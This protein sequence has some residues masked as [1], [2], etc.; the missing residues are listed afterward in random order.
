[1]DRD[2]TGKCVYVHRVLIFTIVYDHSVTWRNSFDLLKFWYLIWYFFWYF[3]LRLNLYEGFMERN[4]FLF[5]N[6]FIRLRT[7]R[8]RETYNVSC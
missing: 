3:L 8:D 1:M 5:D 6:L 2:E 4:V 7:K